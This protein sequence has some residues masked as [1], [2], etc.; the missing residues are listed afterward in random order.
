M[1]NRIFSVIGIIV[2]LGLTI[3][4][5]NGCVNKEKGNLKIGANLSLTGNLAYWSTE[6]KKGIEFAKTELDTLNKVDI[7][8]EDNAGKAS[9]AVN[10]F[11]KFATVENVNVVLTCFTP[12]G[13]PLIPLAKEFQI[14]L[15]AT[16]T[17]AENFAADNEWT[18]RDFPTQNQQATELAQFVFNKM[19]LKSGSYLVVNDD[20]G[21]DGARIFEQVFE[22]LGGT[23][24]EGDYFQQTDKNMRNQII[25]VLK[26]NPQFILVVG[27]DQALALVC[28]QIR[29]VN[30]DVKIVGVN[31][32]DASVVW[33]Q[34][35]D[36]GE[37]VV[38]TS[39]YIDYTNNPVAKIFQENYFKKNNEYP[40]YVVVYG[41]TITKYLL[42][43]LHKT[44]PDNEEIRKNLQSLSVG[45][46]RGELKTNT[47]RDI[48]SPIGIYKRENHKTIR[49]VE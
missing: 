22:K 16:V 20:Y 24:Y 32:F 19:S 6:L 38:F 8:F 33:E 48:I 9:E 39:A 12:I 11:K 7:L 40:N 36:A 21:K 43:I 26:N 14:P 10:I 25:K 2:L 44:G 1:K 27:R 23:F 29:E 37:G 42:D 34:I 5:L 46:I 18:F 45:S 47:V 31:A 41:Y 30:K 4:F 28:R 17:S 49:I 13:Q 35:G 15:V 3:S